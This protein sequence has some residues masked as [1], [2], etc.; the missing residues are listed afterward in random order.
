[1]ICGGPFAGLRTPGLVGLDDPLVF[2][3]AQRSLLP[4]G[5]QSKLGEHAHDYR[6][7]GHSQEDF[8]G[9]HDR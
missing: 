2:L 8:A 6:L 7:E 3:S 1:M 4:V 9:R 5:P